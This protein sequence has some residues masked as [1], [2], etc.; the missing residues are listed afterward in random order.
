MILE[1]SA[2]PGKAKCRPRCS[3]PSVCLKKEIKYEPH[4]RAVG[5]RQAGRHPMGAALCGAAERDRKSTRLNSS[6]VR[7]SYAVF[8]LKKKKNTRTELASLTVNELITP[9]A[10]STAQSGS[11]TRV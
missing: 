11:A 7:I 1:K 9:A 4:R 6:H 8:C 2:W 3:G 10:K 5:T